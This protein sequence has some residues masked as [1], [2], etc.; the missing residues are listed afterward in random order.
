MSNL[1]PFK[2][3]STNWDYNLTISSD[4]DFRTL[5]FQFRETQMDRAIREGVIQMLN[6]DLRKRVGL[7]YG[8]VSRANEAT[9]AW[10]N[11]EDYSGQ[12]DHRAMEGGEER[13]SV[14]TVCTRHTI[15]VRAER[16]RLAKR[17]GLRRFSVSHFLLCISLHR[18]T[19]YQ[20]FPG[21]PGTWQCRDNERNRIPSRTECRTRVPRSYQANHA[22]HE[23][24]ETGISLLTE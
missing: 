9:R 23:A 6:D 10:L 4:L 15:E 16:T 14:D 12:L 13:H 2:G 22:Q 7:A 20:E 17:Q 8:A 1:V 24:N 19:A 11:R 21:E 18:A 5:G 3:C